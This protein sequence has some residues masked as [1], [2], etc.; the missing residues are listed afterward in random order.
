MTTTGTM[1][2]SAKSS[3]A[4]S[5]ALARSMSSATMNAFSGQSSQ[6]SLPS[7]RALFQNSS[8]GSVERN[9]TP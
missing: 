5:S 2:A 3:V 8:A 1:S 6:R 7:G 4:T 9:A